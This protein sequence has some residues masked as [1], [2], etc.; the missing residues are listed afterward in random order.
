M[1]GYEDQARLQQFIGFKK[2]LNE[3]RQRYIEIEKQFDDLCEE[4]DCQP[5]NEQII[6][7]I[8]NH[9]TLYLSEMDL[10]KLKIQDISQIIEKIKSELS[11]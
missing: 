7:E 11:N 3:L 4:L 2:I 10:I 5:I 8:S 1:T 6:Y 9:L